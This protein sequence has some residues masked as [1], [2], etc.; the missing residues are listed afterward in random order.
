IGELTT[1]THNFVSV[2]DSLEILPMRHIRV[3][4]S[5]RHDGANL[6]RLEARANDERTVAPQRRI[7][8]VFGEALG[9]GLHANKECHSENDA[10]Q[11]E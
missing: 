11:T 10:A 4:S 2:G 7:D 9:L 8:E 1:D 3:R 6:T 5:S